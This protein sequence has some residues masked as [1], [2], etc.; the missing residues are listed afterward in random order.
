MICA[1]N[2]KTGASHPSLSLTVSAFAFAHAEKVYVSRVVFGVLTAIVCD[3]LA[4][5]SLPP[6]FAYGQIHLLRQME[7]GVVHTIQPD[8][9]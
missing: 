9:L 4:A 7:A 5:F 3:M 8:K 6:S 2:L 1:F